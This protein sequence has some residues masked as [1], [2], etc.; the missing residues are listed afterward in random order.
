M[1][2]P[3]SPATQAAELW[4]PS[5][6]FPRQPL[7][8]APGPLSILGPGAAGPVSQPRV[9]NYGGL[10]PMDLGPYFDPRARTMQ[11]PTDA[12]AAEGDLIGTP[13][14]PHG[15]AA[16]FGEPDGGPMPAKTQYSVQG[17]MELQPVKLSLYDGPCVCVH[18][19]INCTGVYAY[20]VASLLLLPRNVLHVRDLMEDAG[21]VRVTRRLREAP[22]TCPCRIL[23]GPATYTGFV[24]FALQYEDTP[25]VQ[26]PD[27]KALIQ[28]LNGVYVTGVM[29]QLRTC[30]NDNARMNYARA[31][32]PRAYLD[33]R[34]EV[35]ADYGDVNMP[36]PAVLP[37]GI[38][39]TAADTAF[40]SYSLTNPLATPRN[41]A[42]FAAET[43]LYVGTRPVVL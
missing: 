43:G 7:T 12:A 4:T 11:A 42:A 30:V 31:E 37:S 35:E 21:L 10:N 17:P 2:L 23:G 20:S 3:Y 14:L 15:P 39:T 9:G 29:T 38:R 18:P 25:F 33:P 1:P 19:T 40:A 8:T 5:L 41:R 26:M 6:S 24:G 32:G 22:L 16:F 36:L 34:P 27:P 13:A 28:Y